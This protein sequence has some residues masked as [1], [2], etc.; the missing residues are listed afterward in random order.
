MATYPLLLE[1]EDFFKRAPP[2][3]LKALADDDL[4]AALKGG[5]DEAYSYLVPRF[6]PPFSEYGDDLRQH[7]ASLVIWHVLGRRGGQSANPADPYFARYQA[8]IRWLEAVRDRKTTPAGLVDATPDP[9]P[10][11]GA[12]RL[13]VVTSPRRGW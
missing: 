13:Y 6:A 10:A 4:D 1:R 11:P 8:A 2:T 5:S 3:L 7:V 12:G 9:V